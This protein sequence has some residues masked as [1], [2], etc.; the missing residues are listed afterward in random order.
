MSM[1]TKRERTIICTPTFESESTW[2]KEKTGD[3]GRRGALTMLTR[4]G[5]FSHLSIV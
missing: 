1:D 3:L 4:D 2:W 5:E